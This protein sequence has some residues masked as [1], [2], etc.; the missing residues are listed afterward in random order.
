MISVNASTGKPRWQ[1]RTDGHRLF[2]SSPPQPRVTESSPAVCGGV[3]YFVG[4][5]GN[6]HAVSAASGARRWVAPMDCDDRSSVAVDGGAVY[7]RGFGGTVFALDAATGERR[8]QQRVNATFDYGVPAVADGR[9]YVAGRRAESATGGLSTAGDLYAFDAATGHL[10]WQVPTDSWVESSPAVAGGTVYVATRGS[11][12]AMA[13]LSAVDAAAGA[14]R[15]RTGINFRSAGSALPVDGVRSS[16]TFA[17]GVL[18]LGNPNGYLYAYRAS[19]G[20][21][22]GPYGQPPPATCGPGSAHPWPTWPR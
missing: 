19:T 8:W 12:I 21:G 4:V 22:A 1:Y 2:P 14:V 7:G 6:V 9:V 15:W 18:Y 20:A 3:V 5:D 11:S 17:D 10:D 13:T 16:P